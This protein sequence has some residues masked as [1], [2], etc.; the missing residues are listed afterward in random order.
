MRQLTFSEI[1]KLLDDCADGNLNAVKQ[2]GDVDFNVKDTLERVPVSIAAFNGHTELVKYL[3]EKG[4]DINQTTLLCSGALAEASR[5]GYLEL[6]KFLY[7]LSTKG[8]RQRALGVAVEHNHQKVVHYLL[9]KGVDVN[10][11]IPQVLGMETPLG[12]AAQEG[13][14]DMIR[15]LIQKGAVFPKEP[16]LETYLE[17]VFHKI[18]N[19]ICNPFRFPTSV[20]EADLYNP[21]N[22]ALLYG[23]EDA[24][25]FLIK[26]GVR[27]NSKTPTLTPL[28]QAIIGGNLNCVKLVVEA[29]ADLFLGNS[30]EAILDVARKNKNQEI[31]DYIQY[32]QENVDTVQP[33]CYN[34]VKKQVMAEIQK[35]EPSERKYLP[36]THTNLYGTL[37]AYGLLAEWFEQMNYTSQLEV[38]KVHRREMNPIVRSKVEQVM[39]QTRGRG[40]W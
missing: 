38:Y 31:I 26:Q 4:A 13:R 1:Q 9:K 35:I 24:A 14:V 29:G 40:E 2:L 37:V 11:I 3:Y 39:R 20:N 36:D 34:Y 25:R 8:I 22:N 5:N 21:L 12:L 27:I 19:I 18:K 6:V 33:Q 17:R 30:P 23:K 16:K 10:A 32:A 15:F 7:P 28:V